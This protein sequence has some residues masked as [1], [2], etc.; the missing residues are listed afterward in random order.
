MR[1]Q[2]PGAIFGHHWPPT[3]ISVHCAFISKSVRRPALQFE[4]AP[5]EETPMRE[6]IRPA[7]TALSIVGL[8]AS[9]AVISTDSALAR[10]EPQMAPA[11]PAAT[12]PAMKQRAL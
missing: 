3:S 5:T 6:F 7:V 4:T 12:P 2:W 1:R 10:S 9:I 11:P 8:A